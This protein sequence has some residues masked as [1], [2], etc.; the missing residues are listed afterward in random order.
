LHPKLLYNSAPWVSID[1]QSWVVVNQGRL[2]II[3]INIPIIELI[4]S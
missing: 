1:V 3:K 2:V 4:D